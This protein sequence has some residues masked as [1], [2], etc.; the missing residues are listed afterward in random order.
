M[1]L[2]GGVISIAGVSYLM[3][4]V[5]AVA[6]LGYILGRVSIKGISLGTAGV[7]IVALLFGALFY[8]ELSGVLCVKDSVGQSVSYASQAL[9]V[10]ENIGLIFFVT[11]VGFIAG[12]NFF[13]NLKKNYKSYILLG[14]IVILSGGL[15][16]VG[17]Y[18]MGRGS[19]SDPKT[20]LALLDGI[21]SGALTSTPGFSSAK[22]TVGAAY[23]EAV[24]VGYGIAYLFGVV[25]V[26]LFVQ[27]MP[28]IMRADM[29]K[30]R[31][32]LAAVNTGGTKKQ[33]KGK[34]LDVDPIGIAAFTLA[35]MIGIFV[36]SIKIPLSSAGLSG[37]TF[38][39]TTTGGTLITALVFGHF[40]HFGPINVM[41]GKKMLEI[42]RELG[43][44][45]F[46]MGAGISGGAKFV[47]YFKPIYFLYGVI[48]TL[49]PMI[50][51]FFF[52]KYVLKL[53]LLNNL[54][55]ITGGMT[56][57]PA[58]GTLISVAKT[59]D[60]ASAYA[61]TYPIALLAVVLVSQFLWIL[62]A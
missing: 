32:L 31:Q 6:I 33:Y 36:G 23:E 51:G 10:I 47:E 34:L 19:E 40:G 16:C 21:L 42:F 46:L 45:F 41:P 57:T 60:V 4:I 25:G 30:E 58:L 20:F 61:A 18:F 44:M 22:A 28:R 38:S 49:L 24:T 53:S 9:K 37:T 55:S 14:V 59:E 62:F 2:F 43:L 26:V 1:D 39:L 3:L 5:M 12:P 27:L 7:F 54:G 17:C 56:S 8:E 35:A 48:I 52:A 15:A 50:I 29:D 11:A 13:K